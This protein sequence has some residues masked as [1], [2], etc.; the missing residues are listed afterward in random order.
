MGE[1]MVL[2]IDPLMNFRGTVSGGTIQFKFLTIL[3]NLHLVTGK[4]SAAYGANA[5]VIE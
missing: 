1:M 3:R 5:L 2:R 4:G